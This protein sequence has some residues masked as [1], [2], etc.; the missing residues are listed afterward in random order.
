MSFRVRAKQ[1]IYGLHGYRTYRAFLLRS[2]Y[3]ELEMDLRSAFDH[4]DHVAQEPEFD[5]NRAAQ[6]VEILDSALPELERP[7]PNLDVVDGDL[8]RARRLMVWVKPEEWINPWAATIE[9]RL[10]LS[11]AEEARA[12]KL[13]ADKPDGLRSRLVQAIE[14][15]DRVRTSDAINNGLQVRR[16]ELIRNVGYVA[17]PVLIFCAPILVSQ[18]SLS[19]WN[20]DELGIS[21]PV[22]SWLTT[23]GVAVLGAIGALLSGLLQIRRSPVTFTDYEVRGIEVA[24]RV[25]VGSAVAVILYYLLSWQVLPAISVTS[26]GTFLLVAFAAGF[27]ERY[28]LKLLGLDSAAHAADQARVLAQDAARAAV[29]ATPKSA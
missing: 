28:F 12:F 25:L 8:G 5:Y 10:H 15:L 27:S 3:S 23:M 6:V 20:V 22:D 29:Q 26:A 13:G 9:A 2:D 24:L 16:L 1:T 19:L 11:R 21:V 17:V 7:E 4:C 14:I 18:A